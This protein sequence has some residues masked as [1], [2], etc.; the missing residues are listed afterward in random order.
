LASRKQSLDAGLA[1]FDVGCQN[2]R[3][4]RW[5]RR[6]RQG[7]QQECFHGVKTNAVYAAKRESRREP[8]FPSSGRMLV[9]LGRRWCRDGEARDRLGVAEGEAPAFRRGS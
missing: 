7:E 3:A 5:R 6:K 4:P 1:V 8:F 2:R 9:M